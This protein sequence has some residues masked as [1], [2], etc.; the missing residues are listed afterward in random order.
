VAFSNPITGGQGGLIRPSIKSPNFVHNVSGWTIDRN[1]NAEFNNG[2]FRGTITASTFQGTDFTINSAGYFLYNGAPAAGNLAFSIAQ[3]SGTDAFG[4]V[5][6]A[7]VTGYFAD[8]RTAYKLSANQAGVITALADNANPQSVGFFGNSMVTALGADITANAS[9]TAL[10][11]PDA[12][13]RLRISSATAGAIVYTMNHLQSHGSFGAWVPDSATWQ[14]F[15]V[16]GAP[17]YKADWSGATS[18]HGLGGIQKLQARITAE[19]ELRLYGLATAAAGAGTTIATLAAGYFSATS[20]LFGECMIATAAGVESRAVFAIDTTGNI[21]LPV[22][23]VTG[24]VYGF[25]CTVPLGNV[26]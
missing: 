9:V 14:V 12:D 13:G 26:A 4:N 6:V 23:A 19:D 7:G 5:Y 2:T 25:N 1:G 22:A 17:A 10:S 11:T 3:A 20:T 16:G 21:L 8:G 18:F 15:G 24:D